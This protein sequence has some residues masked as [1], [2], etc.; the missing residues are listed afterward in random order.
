MPH[1]CVFF[2]KVGFSPLALIA[3]GA[4]FATGQY[5]PPTFQLGCQGHFRS[6]TRSCLKVRWCTP[7]QA[8]SVAC[9][10]GNVPRGTFLQFAKVFH[11]EHFTLLRRVRPSGKAEGNGSLASHKALATNHH[12]L[13][14]PLPTRH[15]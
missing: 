5:I 7:T 9:H 15:H 14:R 6:Y 2:T 13:H 3:A 12:L 10:F 8:E 4:G 1:L 11:V